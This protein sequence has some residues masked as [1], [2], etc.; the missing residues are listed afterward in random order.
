MKKEHKNSGV[1]SIIILVM[2][3]IYVQLIIREKQGG[4][5]ILDEIYQYL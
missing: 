4:G 3:I 2:L 1:L 5:K